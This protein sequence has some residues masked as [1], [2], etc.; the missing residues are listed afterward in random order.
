MQVVDSVTSG[1]GG[2][3]VIRRRDGLQRTG[4][5]FSWDDWLRLSFIVVCSQEHFIVKRMWISDR[6]KRS[7]TSFFSSTLWGEYRKPCGSAWLFGKGRTGTDSFVKGLIL[8]QNERWRR[9]LGM[10]VER[11]W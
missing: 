2:P 11:A 10:Q 8:A 9:G 4:T 6:E 1:L 7:A 3:Q 5:R